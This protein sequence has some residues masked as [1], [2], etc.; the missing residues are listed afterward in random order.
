MNKVMRVAVAV[1]LV[2]AI[3]GAAAWGWFVWK[4][5]ADVKERV[6]TVLKDPN[7]AEFRDVEYFA[8]SGAGCGLVNAKNGMGAYIGFTSFIALEDGDVRFRPTDDTESGTLERRIAALTKVIDF[9]Q[10]AEANCP[11][12]PDDK[13]AANQ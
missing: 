5:V 4:P 7:S 3:G 9:L 2:T 6:R 11:A 1:V 10:L 12:P 13:P 8:K